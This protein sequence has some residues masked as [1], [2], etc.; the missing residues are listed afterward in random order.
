MSELTVHITC[1][2]VE[3]TVRANKLIGGLSGEASF[4][5]T[6]SDGT[7]YALIPMSLCAAM[8]NL[9]LLFGVKLSEKTNGF[10]QVKYQPWF[11][12]HVYFT[13]F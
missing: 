13:D 10:D 8:Q 11:Q 5:R 7:L 12:K 2:W 9:Y 3:E 1:T 4:V 6:W